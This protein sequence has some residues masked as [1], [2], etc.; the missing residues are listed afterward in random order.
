MAYSQKEDAQ[1]IVAAIEVALNQ[2]RGLGAEAQQ[3]DLTWNDNPFEWG[4]ELRRAW[5][6]GFSEAEYKKHAAQS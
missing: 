3:H 1:K 4:H 6:E 5:H 2:A